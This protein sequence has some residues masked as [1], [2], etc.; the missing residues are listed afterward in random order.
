MGGISEKES[1][2]FLVKRHVRLCP[3][4]YLSDLG[5]SKLVGE[6]RFC[7]YDCQGPSAVIRLAATYVKVDE[8]RLRLCLISRH[9]RDIQPFMVRAVNGKSGFHPLV[10]RTAAFDEWLGLVTLGDF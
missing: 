6:N 7:F 8:I 10:S 3:Q 1:S 2:F 9:A 5:L 4:P